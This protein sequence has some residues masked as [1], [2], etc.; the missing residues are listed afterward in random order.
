MPLSDTAIRNAKPQ[1]KPAKLYDSGGLFLLVT[2]IGGKW[3]RLKYRFGGK[4]KLLSLGTYPDI[5]LKDARDRR[6]AAKKLLANGGDPSTERRKQ[7]L[8]TRL[9]AANTFGA[10]ADELLG[11]KAK[12]LAATTQTKLK[13][14]LD[15]DL[16]PWLG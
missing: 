10:V 6:D 15:N 2:P 5:S 13:G 8:E 16:R 9:S 1:A 14:I 7:K 11:K 4:E 12:K 3:W